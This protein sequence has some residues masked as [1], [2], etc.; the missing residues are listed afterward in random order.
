MCLGWNDGADVRR[1]HHPS[2]LKCGIRT[3]KQRWSFWMMWPF[4][5]LPP[6]RSVMVEETFKEDPFIKT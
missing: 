6:L 1:E 4:S 5:V 2:W 3:R